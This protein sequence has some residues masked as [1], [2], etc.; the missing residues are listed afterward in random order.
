MRLPTGTEPAA[1]PE[2]EYTPSAALQ[3]LPTPAAA[4]KVCVR[5]AE[6][7]NFQGSRLLAGLDASRR[8]FSPVPQ[9]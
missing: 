3:P 1:P 4:V 7:E 9:R 6:R 5:G 2:I 8:S